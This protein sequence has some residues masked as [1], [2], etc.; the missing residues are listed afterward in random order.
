MRVG[1]AHFA[2]HALTALAPLTAPAIA[3]PSDDPGAMT[4]H[5]TVIEAH[6]RVTPTPI[7]GIIKRNEFEIVVKP[8][9]EI[10]ENHRLID[11]SS[12]ASAR[13]TSGG[14]SATLGTATA[15]VAW[16]VLGPNRLQRMSQNGQ[17]LMVWT[18][19]TDA[20]RGCRIDAKYLMQEGVTVTTGKIQ[21]FDA[22]ATFTNYKV[23][24][25]S[26]TIE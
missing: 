9:K 4:I 5:V 24:Q 2:L 16:H 10:T 7:K 6:D 3:A 26:C 15:S 1:V 13:V 11:E 8:N 14:Q 17:M 21:G 12:R 18:I 25:A 20:G 22:P 23:L 19:E